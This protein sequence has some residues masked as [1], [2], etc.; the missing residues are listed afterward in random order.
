MSNPLTLFGPDFARGPFAAH[1]IETAAL[2]IATAIAQL[3]APLKRDDAELN[4]HAD[5]IRNLADRLAPDFAA[6]LISDVG[7]EVSNEIQTEIRTALGTYSLLHCWLAD[8]VGGGETAV[9]PTSVTWLAGVVLQTITA[10]RSFLVIT[11]ATGAPSVKVAYG[12][13]HTW[14]WAASRLGR[15]YYSPQLKFT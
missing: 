5:F 14:Y 11:P 1:R 10:N 12:G 9:A 13:A 2:Q 7:P 4:D 6:Q 15:V 8:S 3:R